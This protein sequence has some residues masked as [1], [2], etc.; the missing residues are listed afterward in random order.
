MSD[1][2]VII[3]NMIKAGAS[4]EDIANHFTDALNAYTEKARKAEKEKAK[5]KDAIALIQM[6]SAFLETHYGEKAWDEE[7]IKTAAK[8]LIASF[9]AVSDLALSFNKI[10]K[11][12]G[13]SVKDGF[14]EAEKFFND[15]LASLR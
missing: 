3:E 2:D 4:S 12:K 6:V 7:A 13:E 10:I 9:D 1:F 8:D 11:P 15:L 5:M 14:A